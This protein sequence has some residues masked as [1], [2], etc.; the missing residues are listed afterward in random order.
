MAESSQASWKIRW[1][2]FLLYVQLVSGQMDCSKAPSESLR[3]VCQQINN[4][5]KNARAASTP[6][7]DGIVL[8]PGTNETEMTFSVMTIPE[9]AATAEECMTLGQGNDEE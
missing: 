7:K 6:E 8:P 4:W 1:I 2:V 3:V 9:V 5:D